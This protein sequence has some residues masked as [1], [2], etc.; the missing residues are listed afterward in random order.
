MPRTTAAHA[1]AASSAAITPT[2][3]P[4]AAIA[5]S[6]RIGQVQGD[7]AKGGIHLNMSK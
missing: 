1:P 6:G 2:H 7:L 3:W 5:T 4:T